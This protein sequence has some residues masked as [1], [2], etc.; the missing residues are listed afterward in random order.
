MDTICD[1]IIWRII[2]SIF[3]LLILAV[4]CKQPERKSSWVEDYDSFYSS[5]TDSL[6]AYPQKVR[7]LTLQ[8]MQ[9]STDSLELYY[10]AVIVLK[11]YLFYSDVDSARHLS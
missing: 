5:V 7:G 3:F 11:T 6:T 9:M 10:F 8:K 2:F 4:S 1:K